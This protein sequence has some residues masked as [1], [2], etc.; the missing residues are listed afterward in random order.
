MAEFTFPEEGRDTVV[1][2]TLS[3]RIDRGEAQA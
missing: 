2:W 3:G 1:S